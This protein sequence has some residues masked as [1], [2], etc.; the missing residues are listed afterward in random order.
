MRSN[1]PR[2]GFCARVRS[3]GGN[4]HKCINP[5]SVPNAVQESSARA[6]ISGQA[7]NSVPTARDAFAR[8]NSSRQQSQAQRC[9]SLVLSPDAPPDRQ[10]LPS[11]SSAA[12]WQP[13]LLL[14]QTAKHER[15]TQRLTEMQHPRRNR[16][17][18]TARMELPMNARQTLKRLS[19][20]AARGHRRALPASVACAAQ[21]AAGNIRA[22]PRCCRRE[23]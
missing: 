16:R 8:H 12:N 1:D 14:R 11:L 10:R 5:T 17:L 9:L 6:G 4:S 18:P 2:Q 3:H 19:H 15:L 13:C 23:S 22:C 20:S 21:A 7:D